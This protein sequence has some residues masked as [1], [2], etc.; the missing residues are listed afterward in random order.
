MFYDVLRD[1]NQDARQP[2]RAAAAAGD[3]GV[4]LVGA[5][6]HLFTASPSPPPLPRMCFGSSV[7]RRRRAALRQVDVLRRDMPRC[8][9]FRI[10]RKPDP[11]VHDTN[12]A[13]SYH[14]RHQTYHDTAWILP[15]TTL[16]GSYHARHCQTYHARSYHARHVFR[17]WLTSRYASMLWRRL[18]TCITV[19][20]IYGLAVSRVK[21]RVLARITTILYYL[22]FCVVEKMGSGGRCGWWRS[23]VSRVVPRNR[24]GVVYC[25]AGAGVAGG[26]HLRADRRDR[27]HHAFHDMHTRRQVGLRRLRKVSLRALRPR[28]GT[29]GH[30]RSR[31]KLVGDCWFVSRTR[32][33]KP[34]AHARRPAALSGTGRARDGLCRCAAVCWCADA[35]VCPCVW[36]HCQGRHLRRA[37]TAQRLPAPQY[38]GEAGACRAVHQRPQRGAPA[39]PRQ[40][41]APRCNSKGRHG[42]P[43]RRL[44]RGAP[45]EGA[46][47]RAGQCGRAREG[48]SVHARTGRVGR[49]ACA[50][51]MQEAAVCFRAAVPYPDWGCGARAVV[52][53]VQ[54]GCFCVCGAARAKGPQPGGLCCTR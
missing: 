14:A 41:R 1:L 16:H 39:N 31:H 48:G 20:R 44:K 25:W 45:G 30:G 29:I 17:G 10:Y 47:E 35:A 27:L 3:G 18:R 15:C 22:V 40:Q 51:L 12:H 32:R 36:V 33:K 6:N 2:S 46:G 43:C 26:D 7:R 5:V 9:E 42:A 37:D 38:Q 21:E 13:R 4:Y 11:T 8:S 52:L 19:C 49:C 54:A 53:G 28:P 34:P 24:F 23:L 50:V